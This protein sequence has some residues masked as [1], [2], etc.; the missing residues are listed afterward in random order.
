MSVSVKHCQNV[1]CSIFFP[2]VKPSSLTH[3][4]GS[5]VGPR[6]GEPCATVRAPIVQR[7]CDEALPRH[8]WLQCL[9]HQDQNQVCWRRETHSACRLGLNYIVLFWLEFTSESRMIGILGCFYNYFLSFFFCLF[10][11]EKATKIKRLIGHF[12][13]E[14]KS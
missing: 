11:S 8:T 12:S 6:C 3:T 9:R 2:S 7:A 10:C 4:A 1:F 13:V 5:Q 14:K